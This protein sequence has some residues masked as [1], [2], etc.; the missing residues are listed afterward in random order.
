MFAKMRIHSCHNDARASV[1][2]AAAVRLFV[3]MSSLAECM[4]AASTRMLSV[5]SG[6]GSQQ[7]SIVRAGHRNLVTTFFDSKEE[8]LRKYPGATQN[9][10]YLES[11]CHVAYEVDA[12]KLQG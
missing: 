1:P 4:T 9:V 2:V 6:D 5:G 11:R 3:K 7:A 12:T 10:E 8:L